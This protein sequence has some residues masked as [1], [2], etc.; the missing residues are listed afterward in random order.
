MEL[1]VGKTGKESVQCTWTNDELTVY[2]NLW[3][4]QLYQTEKGTPTKGSF[5]TSINVMTPIPYVTILN[6]IVQCLKIVFLGSRTS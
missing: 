5:H 2:R 1:K 6:H 3:S 4:K